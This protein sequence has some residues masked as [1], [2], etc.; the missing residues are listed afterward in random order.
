MKQEK[1]RR[2]NF[3]D[4]KTGFKEGGFK[5]TKQSTI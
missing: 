3:I 2:V 4:L 1:Q 5:C